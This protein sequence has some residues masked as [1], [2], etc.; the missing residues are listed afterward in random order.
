MSDKV[1]T[2]TTTRTTFTFLSIGDLRE[3]IDGLPD[4]YVVV[5]A[6][7]MDMRPGQSL[8]RWKLVFER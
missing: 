2:I 6:E 4:D 5:D 7:M 8:P 1:V 3:A